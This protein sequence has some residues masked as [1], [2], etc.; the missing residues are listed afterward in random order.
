MIRNVVS[1]NFFV[2]TRSDKVTKKTI[3]FLIMAPAARKIKFK[4]EKGTK[5]PKSINS[6]N[7]VFI[8][9]APE[10]IKIR[11]NEFKF[12][13]LKYSIHLPE[14]ILSTFL[15]TP[16]L[17]DEGLRLTH[18]TNVNEDRSIQ[19]ELFN[20]T[21]D[22]TFTLRKKSRIALFMTLNEGTEGFKTEFEKI[23]KRKT[24]YRLYVVKFY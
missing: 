8:L 3:H 11:P 5:K 16:A 24:F 17:R 19:L 22:K 1:K 13:F 23:N 10:K 20:K 9:Y 7:S 18:H 14:D 12:A 4:I 21:L 2:C 6:A 15:I